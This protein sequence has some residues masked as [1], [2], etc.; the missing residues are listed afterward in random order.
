MNTVV[1][2]QSV[3]VEADQIIL[4][5]ANG[6]VAITEDL[7][8]Y[9]RWAN[10]PNTYRAL[11]CRIEFGHYCG[12]PYAQ[13]LDGDKVDSEHDARMQIAH[14]LLARFHKAEPNIYVPSP[15]QILQRPDIIE[16]FRRYELSRLLI[17]GDNYGSNPLAD[18]AS[19]MI[20]TYDNYWSKRTK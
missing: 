4:H 5:T 9:T 17:R 11:P 10:D 19:H 14:D 2:V 6:P 8:F 12:G 1:L 16:K 7:E 3:S 20:Q 15:S 18:Y 13:M